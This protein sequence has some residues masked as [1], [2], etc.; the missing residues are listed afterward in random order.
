MVSEQIKLINAGGVLV[1]AM[2]VVL[3]LAAFFGAWCALRWYGGSEIALA[4]RQLP[5]GGL[6]AAQTATRLSPDDALAH[7]SMASLM[8]RG[9][10]PGDLES[11]ISEYRKAA[12]LSPNDFRLWTDLGRALEQAGD[13]DASEKALRRG[14]ELAPYYSWPRWHL[15]NF[16]LRRAR[17]PEA[18]GELRRVAEADPDRRGAIID[19]T[20]AVYG[21]DIKAIR[22]ALGTSTSVQANFISYLLGRKRLDEAMQVWSG[23]SAEQKKEA[24]DTG[25]S[26]VAALIEAKRFRS[27]MTFSRELSPGNAAYEIGQVS[28]GSFENPVAQT[29]AGVFD[30][31]VPSIVQARVALD[32]DKAEAGSLSLRINFNAPGAVDINITQLIAVEPGASYRLTFYLRTN[33]L[34]SAAT[35]LVRVTNVADGK[36]LVESAQVAAGKNEWQKV[37]LDFKMPTD[38]DGIT[39]SINRAACQLEGGVCPIFGTVWYDDFNLQ[40]AGREAGARATG[41][42]K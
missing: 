23:F 33:D 22:E 9:L 31:H 29:G 34:K 4:A 38:A 19:L 7:W 12:S 10:A 32:P 5:E 2:L 17:Y 8:Q 14:V 20:W 39:L 25:G 30:W 18:I 37:S 41:K 24:R 16:L 13:F 15:G 35:T 3:V 42:G 6:D 28:N 21:G 36:V 40:L 1:R 27:A 26:L 11:S